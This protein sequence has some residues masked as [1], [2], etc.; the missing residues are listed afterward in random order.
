[1]KQS[2]F[3]KY[4]DEKYLLS[5]FI[6]EFHH[7]REKRDK[8]IRL[9][10]KKLNHVIFLLEG[11]MNISYNEFRNHLCNAGEMIF[12]P[13]NAVTA[14]ESFT[15][16]RYLLLSFNNQIVLNE[17]FGW[18][19][20]RGLDGDRDVF[21]KLDLRGLMP[22][23]IGSVISYREHGIE[24]SYLDEMKEKEAFLLMKYI[25]SKQEMARFLKPLLTQDMDFKAC[26]IR[27]YDSTRNVGEL[28]GA[29]NLSVRAF[30]RKFKTQFNDSPYQWILKQK[31]GQIKILLADMNKP[32]QS[33]VKEYGFSSPAHFTTYCKKQ[34]GMTPSMYRNILNGRHDLTISGET[35]GQDGES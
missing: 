27:N 19:E 15:E 22:D 30:I 14:I 21:H 13:E 32:M 25:Y 35:A 7:R 12:I 10:G 8:V 6:V 3:D 4:P 9:E 34:F 16:V 26:V 31:A 17:E 23:M 33:I 24:Y 11:E 28:A 5:N 18:D 20:L 2:Y 29:C 1:M